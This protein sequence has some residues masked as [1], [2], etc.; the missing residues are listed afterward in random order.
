MER[1]IKSI[2]VALSPDLIHLFDLEGSVVVVVDI[3]RATSSITTAL[4]Y[5][6]TSVRPV[7][8]LSE[9]RKL[10]EA[11]YVGAAE[12][13]G[14]KVDGFDLGNSPFEYMQ[15]E[16]EGRSIAL[17]TTNGTDAVMRSKGANQIL[18][19]SF[20]NYSV[21]VNY[22]KKLPYDIIIH[23]AGWKGQVNMEDTLFAG[24]LLD[25]L[26]DECDVYSDASEIARHLYQ[27]ARGNLFDF[28]SECSH[29]Q[30][31]LQLGLEDDIRYCLEFDKYNIIPI[32]KNGEIARLTLKDMLF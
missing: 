30:R 12:R 20:L 31:L 24:A 28:L 3:L 8:S 19:G 26:M 6:V 22:L 23:C 9:C 32:L 25:K 1:G 4:A 5:G 7:R 29:V 15:P 10:Q 17:T 2:G 11:G 13:R 27:K 16:L 14:Q 18:I 21:L